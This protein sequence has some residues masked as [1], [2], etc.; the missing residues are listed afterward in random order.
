M[1]PRVPTNFV[2]NINIILMTHVTMMMEDPTLI[3]TN[4][5]RQLFITYRFSTGLSNL[6]INKSSFVSRGEW[7]DHDVTCVTSLSACQL[8]VMLIV[9]TLQEEIK[10]HL[11]T[12][13]L[14]NLTINL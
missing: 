3:E 1:L 6:Y 8:S 4:L 14:L 13:I 5:R 2:K 12:N 11:E 10:G 9:Q 7:R